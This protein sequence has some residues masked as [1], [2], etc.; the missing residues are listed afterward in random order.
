MQMRVKATNQVI[1][2]IPAQTG[3][4]LKFK[5]VN[6]DSIYAWNDL[7]PVRIQVGPAPVQVQAVPI[8]VSPKISGSM[9]VNKVNKNAPPQKS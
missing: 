4:T 1:T 2:V 7:E 3:K 8:K 5:D 9:T 6:S